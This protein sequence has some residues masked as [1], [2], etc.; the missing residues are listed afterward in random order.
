MSNTQKINGIRQTAVNRL[1]ISGIIEVY[2]AFLY[3]QN[4][5]GRTEK[6]PPCFFLFIYKLCV[7]RYNKYMRVDCFI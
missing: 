5:A 2:W 1:P 3:I 7:Q 6:T 4:A